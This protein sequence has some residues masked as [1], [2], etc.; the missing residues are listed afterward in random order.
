MGL[1]DRFKKKFEDAGTDKKVKNVVDEKKKKKE[2]GKESKSLT[3]DEIKRAQ[4][5]EGGAPTAKTAKKND[6]SEKKKE[7]IPARDTK[8]AYRTLV[9]PVFTE[10][11]SLLTSQNAY[12]F[13]V[14]PKASKS[15]IKKAIK[16]VYE[17]TPIAIQVAVVKGKKITFGRI[18]GVTKKWKK[19]IVKLPQGKTIDIYQK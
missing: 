19:A 4:A 6:T 8:N 5:M 7:K 18:D 15:E 11:A 14:H 13:E 12:V 17:V 3:R 9:R 16:A 1:F 10:K 2:S